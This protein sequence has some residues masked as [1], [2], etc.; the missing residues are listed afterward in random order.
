MTTKQNF[1]D[2]KDDNDFGFSF[3]SDEEMVT[4]NPHIKSLQD[5]NRDLKERLY[6]V[7]NIFMPLLV[8][9]SKDPDKPMI[10]WEGRAK[11]IEE[12]IKR[13]DELTCY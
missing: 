10:R 4:S 2:L 5:E 11:V 6:Q 8:N 3:V 1:V 7:H 9:L 12:Q 13:L